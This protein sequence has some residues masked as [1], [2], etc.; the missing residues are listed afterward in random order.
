MSPQTRPQ[1]GPVASHSLPESRH[2]PPT[3]ANVEHKRTA[4]WSS[5]HLRDD[6]RRG[7]GS[8]GVVGEGEGEGEGK[9]HVV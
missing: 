5:L 6:D 7:R 8:K 1:S 2:L 4:A 3:H 9:E